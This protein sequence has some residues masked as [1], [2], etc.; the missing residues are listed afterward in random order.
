MNLQ[1]LNTHATG[2][3][4]LGL[5]GAS[6]A[7]VIASVSALF[8][9]LQQPSFVMALWNDHLHH[10]FGEATSTIVALGFGVLGSCVVAGIGAIASYWGRPATIPQPPALAGKGSP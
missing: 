5:S 8:N 6:I 3:V 1:A 10:T 7:G 2:Y 9:R 4:G